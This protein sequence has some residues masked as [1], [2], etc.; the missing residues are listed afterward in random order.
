MAG[1][2]G[3]MN[4]PEDARPGTTRRVRLRD[5]DYRTPGYYFVTICVHNRVHLFGCVREGAM[6]LNDAGRMITETTAA[7]TPRHPQA[8]VDAFVVMPN[9]V[10]LLLGINLGGT[11]SLPEL[12]L[13]DAVHWWKTRTTTGYID[14]VR[15]QGWTPYEHRFWQEGYHDH[16]VRNDRE[17]D[18]I[19]NYIGENPARWGQDVFHDR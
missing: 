5:Y 7:L 11:G 10:H 8:V 14:G 15:G 16:I 13:I 12:S 4:R 19:R 2:R 1:E 17:L 3:S 18:M 6:Q 9:H